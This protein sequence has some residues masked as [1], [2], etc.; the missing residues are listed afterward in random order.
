MTP[1]AEGDLYAWIALCRVSGGG[2]AKLGD[3]YLDRGHPTPGLVTDALEKLLEGGLLALTG[4]DRRC[5]VDKKQGGEIVLDAHVTGACV[6]IFDEDAVTAL[7][8]VL[9]EWLG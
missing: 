9:G 5:P 3:R 8:D 7:F 2:A 1:L 6:T 4:P